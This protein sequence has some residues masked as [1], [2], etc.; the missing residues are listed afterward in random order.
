MIWVHL[1]V[2]ENELVCKSRTHY[3]T[4]VNLNTL[5]AIVVMDDIVD[6][7]D[8]AF[9]EGSTLIVKENRSNTKMILPH[10]LGMLHSLDFPASLRFPE[11]K[12][13]ERLSQS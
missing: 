4:I 7:N 5:D 11:K 10:S 3:K 8:I 13:W 2:S 1:E 6:G 9:A 12:D